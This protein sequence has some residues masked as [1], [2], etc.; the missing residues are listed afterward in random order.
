MIYEDNGKKVLLLNLEK[1]V[2]KNKEDIEYIVNQEGALNQFGLKVV[3]Q[4]D[5]IGDM[6]TVQAYKESNP[7]WEYGDAFMV[8]VSTAEA[9]VVDVDNAIFL[10]W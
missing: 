2:Q 10:N 7:N 4:V 9:T 1:Q 3:G 8:G 5:T 6:P